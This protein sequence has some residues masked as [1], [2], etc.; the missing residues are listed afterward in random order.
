MQFLKAAVS[1]LLLTIPLLASITAQAL[2]STIVDQQKLLVRQGVCETNWADLSDNLDSKHYPMGDGL[3]VW[4]VP[5]AH[6]AVNTDWT[7]YM[8][9]PESS[10]PDGSLYTQIQFIDYSTYKGMYA[11]NV[12]KN[13]QIDRQA[14]TLTG[15]QSF[16]TGGLCGSAGLFTY[17]SDQQ[18]FV[19]SKLAKSDEC[20]KPSPWKIIY[21]SAQ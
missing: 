6:W 14:K 5:C 17:N 8:Q 7:V 4:L 3:E 20:K 9:I 1:S 18:T 19:L 16:D 2:P 13:V 12:I 15:N 10:Q 21:P 11:T